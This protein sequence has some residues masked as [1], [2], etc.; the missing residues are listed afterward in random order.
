[1]KHGL[2]IKQKDKGKAGDDEIVIIL[3]ETGPAIFIDIPKDERCQISGIH[4]ACLGEKVVD[5]GFVNFL[6][7]IVKYIRIS[8]LS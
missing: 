1:M 2:K 5:T 6:F 3:A 7:Q 4:V 8:W